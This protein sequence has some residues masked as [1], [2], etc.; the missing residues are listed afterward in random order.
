MRRRAAFSSQERQRQLDDDSQG[1]TQ[2][3]AA[4]LQVEDDIEP[5]IAAQQRRPGDQQAGDH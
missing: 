2:P 5:D 1:D 3:H 4:G